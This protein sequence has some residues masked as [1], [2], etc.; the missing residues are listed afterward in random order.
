MVHWWN[1][2]RQG[3]TE[4]PGGTPIPT[5]TAHHISHVDCAGSE[6]EFLGKVQISA[7]TMAKHCKPE[8]YISFNDC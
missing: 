8:N 3:E 1:D 2:V 6:Q 7:W 4:V 5:H